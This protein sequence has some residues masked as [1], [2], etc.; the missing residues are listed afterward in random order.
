[1]QRFMRKS[2]IYG[3]LAAAMCAVTSAHAGVVI[4]GTRLVYHG[5]DKEASIQVMNSAN[6]QIP[7]LIQSFVDDKGPK[8][9]RPGTTGSLPFTVTQP[10]FRLDA[11]SENT[12]RVVRTGGNFPADRE[13]VYW[14]DVKAI[15]ANNPADKGKNVLRFSLKNRI[16]LFY[17]PKGVADPTSEAMEAI[18]FHRTGNKLTVTN[19]TPW[20]LSFFKLNVGDKVVDTAFT[21]VAP[22]GSTDYTIPAGAGGKITWQYINDYGAGSLVLDG[23]G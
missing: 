9:D 21:M 11:G 13:S 18:G 15:P 4:G 6:G 22:H 16:K 12:I 23:K 14:L 2:V 19:P 5:G 1:M 17:R 10:L 20:Y 3:L 8:G 7:Y